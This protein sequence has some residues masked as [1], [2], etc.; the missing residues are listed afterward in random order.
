MSVHLKAN[1]CQH[2]TLSLPPCPPLFELSHKA[3]AVAWVSSAGASWALLADPVYLTHIVS[4][5]A[6]V[7]SSPAQHC[8]HCSCR[9][10][11]WCR[12]CCG[13][14][15]RNVVSVFKIRKKKNLCMR[16]GDDAS[17]PRH[18]SPH[19]SPSFL[20]PIGHHSH[21]HFCCGLILVGGRHSCH[22]GILQASHVIVV[23]V[24]IP[25]A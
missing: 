1:Q 7:S 5:I 16:P 14:A 15:H 13:P 12:S 2:P 10:A 19:L 22:C 6:M 23:P 25:C 24:P 8:L 18:W 11:P 20:V 3:H 21:H 4:F 17:Q 9:C